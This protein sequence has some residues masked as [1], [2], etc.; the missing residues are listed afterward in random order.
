M[1]LP[2]P[3]RDLDLVLD[4]SGGDLAG[5]SDARVFL[6]GGTG[7]FG[8]WLVETWLRARSGRGRG[9]LHVLSRDPEA[10]F[11]RCPHLAGRAGLHVHRGSQ[12]AFAFPAGAFDA[13]I[14]GAVAQGPLGPTFLENLEGTARVL[15]FARAAGAARVLFLSSGAVYGAQPP[16]LSHLPESHTGMR[17]PLEEAS[18]YGLAKAGSEFLA[19]EASRTGGPAVVIARPFAFVGPGLP[20]DR[21]YAIG[22]FIRDALGKGPLRIEGDG[23]PLR[24]YL[25]AGDLAVWLWALLVRGSDRKAYNVGSPEAISITD[26]A[27]RV[28]VVLCP[29]RAVSIAGRPDPSR[30]ASRYVPDTSLAERELGLRVAV[31]LDEAIRRTADWARMGVESWA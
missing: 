26:L 17:T 8:R 5:L 21:N 7:F 11:L 12:A 24:S 28:R 25:Y 14:H 4:L 10:W 3:S 6:T 16:T 22:N 19:C 23:T 15:A 18:A 2:L 27:D 29:D 20:L 9:E 31:P 30:P 13:V 1:D